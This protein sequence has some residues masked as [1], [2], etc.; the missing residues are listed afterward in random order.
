[1]KLVELVVSASPFFGE[2][3]SLNFSSKL[4]CIMG[5]RGSGKTTVLMLIQWILSNDDSLPRETLALV[6]ANLGSG[7]VELVLEDENSNVFRL[8]KE[9]GSNVAIRNQKGE[10]I[11]LEEVKRR[12]DIDHFSAGSIERI[13]LD[14]KERLKIF[15][16]YI[17]KEI[18]DV[19]SKIAEAVSEL[20]RNNTQLQ[21]VIREKIHLEE[22][23][24]NFVGLED[25]IAA[26]KSEIAATESD[27][28]VKIAF[29]AET[30]KQAQ[31]TI[32]QNF[33]AKAKEQ[34]TTIHRSNLDYKQ[35][36]K[37]ATSSLQSTKYENAHVHG[38]Q[39]KLVSILTKIDAQIDET[40]ELLKSTA[41]DLI[42]AQT[43]TR[44]DHQSAESAFTDIKQKIEKHRDVFQKLNI[45]TQKETA[46]KIAKEKLEKVSQRVSALENERK[47]NLRKVREGIVERGAVRRNH[48]LAINERLGGNVKILVRDCALSEPFDKLIR[49]VVSDS[50]MR[51]TATELRIVDKSDPI[52]FLNFLTLDNPSGYADKIGVDRTRVRDLFESF[53][54]TN[55]THDLE[56]CICEDS[57][58]FFLAVEDGENHESFKATEELSMG[59]RC[60]AVLPVIFAV[61]EH[62]LLIDQPEDNLDNRY[63][64]RSVQKII[65]DVKDLRQLVFVTH[66]PN[67]PVI[68]DSEFNVFLDFS[69]KHSKITSEGSIAS[70]KQQIVSLLEGGQEAFMKRK[71]FYGY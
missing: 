71:E 51:M 54:E 69:D 11:S 17:G 23:L 34:I 3:I 57:P 15:D 60:T 44:D 10:S 68:S 1:M 63:I 39:E 70:V 18:E 56:I 9:F 35:V 59:Q 66:N 42:A 16:R 14:P 8:T 2:K 62:P 47:D 50:N 21:I 61:T 33:F 26:A 30:N 48:A 24:H 45:T 4:N 58:N 22:D 37:S 6:K 40:I 19:K 52:D 53:R 55:S 43:K 41:Q 38:F 20:E 32:E 46:Q 31:R 64:V 12:F 36:I 27:E 7:S 65:R 28:S 13:G 49:K 25:E 29:E 67:I 5:G